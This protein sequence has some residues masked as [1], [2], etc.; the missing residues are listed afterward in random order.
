MSESQPSVQPASIPEP[1][2]RPEP[3]ADMRTDMREDD[4]RARAERRAAELLGHNPDIGE[5]E[6]GDKFN[7]DRDIIPDGWDYEWKTQTVL[8][9]EDPAAQVQ[10]ANAGWEPVPASR[11]PEFMPET[12]AG[13][14]IDRMG[15]RLMERPESITAKARAYELRK[16]R[17]QVRAKEEQLS[18]PPTGQFERANKDQILVRVKKTFEAPMAIPE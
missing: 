15:M 1:I 11:H 14:T 3:R 16:A 12:Y 17:A 13:R 7:I 4:P 8:G 2:E 9:A 18:S 6:E 5:L 10:T